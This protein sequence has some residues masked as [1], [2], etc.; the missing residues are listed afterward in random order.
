MILPTDERCREILDA[1]ED[2]PNL[3]TWEAEFVESNATRKTFTDP[4]RNVI[5]KFL[6]KYDV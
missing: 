6:D 5:A 3:T 4:Q 1:L 2:E